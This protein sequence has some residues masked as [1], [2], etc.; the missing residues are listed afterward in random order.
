MKIVWAEEYSDN[1]GNCWRSTFYDSGR[2]LRGRQVATTS[3][4]RNNCRPLEYIPQQ[5]FFCNP[6]QLKLGQQTKYSFEFWSTKITTRKTL[7]H[8]NNFH[9]ENWATCVDFHVWLTRNLATT[10]RIE[11]KNL[12]SRR[13]MWKLCWISMF[14]FVQWVVDRKHRQ[15]LSTM[16]LFHSFYCCSSEFK[17]FS[18]I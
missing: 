18:K 9:T 4:P 2:G 17:N 15:N 11:A 12:R 7:L 14:M 13:W 1:D 5:L 16:F 3:W 6:S 10:Q 8:L